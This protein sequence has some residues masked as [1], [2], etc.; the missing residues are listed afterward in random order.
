MSLCYHC[1]KE[2]NQ[3]CEKCG[4]PICQGCSVTITNRKLLVTKSYCQKC[5]KRIF[6]TNRF[7]VFTFLIFAIISFI[8]AIAALTIAVIIWQRSKFS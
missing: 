6:K 7:F 2:T 3:I 8:I 1:N 4:K 5:S